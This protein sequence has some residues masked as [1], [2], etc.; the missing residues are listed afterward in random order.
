MTEITRV[1]VTGAQGQLGRELVAT[2]PLGYELHACGRQDLDVS[3]ATAVREWIASNRPNLVINT[4]GFT[5]VDRAETER[6]SAY[7][8]NCQAAGYLA[9]SVAQIGGRLIHISTD[10]VFDG[11]R[12]T[13]YRPDDIPRPLSVYGESKLG[14]ERRVSEAMGQ[15]AMVIRTSW[16]YSSHGTNFLR[17]MLG[18]MREREEIRVVSDQIGTPTWARGL[19]QAIWVAAD[20]PELGGISHWTDAGVASWYD[21][22]V[23]IQE[24]AMARGLLS[25]VVS[26]IPIRTKD[27][28][29]VAVRPAYSV[30]DK[31]DTWKSLGYIPPH[32]RQA[33]R[34]LIT[35]IAEEQAP[36]RG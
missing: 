16:V 35:E 8:V 10:Y 26:I 31:H 32:W 34:T 7:R 20:R 28:S 36:R 33:L 3:D 25:R 4:A 12:S 18:L 23:A 2:K 24:E 5:A 21:F 22:A 9:E 1:L 27:Y 30:L 11:T 6:D 17:T 29:A 19:A 14:G 15:R 13:P